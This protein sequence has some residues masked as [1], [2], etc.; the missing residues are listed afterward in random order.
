MSWID[1]QKFAGVIFWITENHFIL[2][3]QTWSDNIIIKN[4]D[5]KNIIRHIIR[6]IIYNT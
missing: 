5:I 4:K 3:H 1:L 2:Y 6:I